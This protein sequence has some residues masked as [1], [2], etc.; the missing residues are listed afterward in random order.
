MQA[1]THPARGKLGP[2]QRDR[3]GACIR[4]YLQEP[5]ADDDQVKA[6]CLSAARRGRLG[7]LGGYHRAGERK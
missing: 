2:G 5:G 6:K 1:T 3:V 7:V 4:R